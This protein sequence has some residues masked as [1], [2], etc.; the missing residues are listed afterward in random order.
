MHPFVLDLLERH[1]LPTTGLRSKSWNEFAQPGAPKMDF[2]ITVCDKARAEVC[3]VWPGQ[4]LSAH[5]GVED[6]IEATGDEQH[7]R[8]A[9]SDA[10]VLLSRRIAIFANLPLEKLGRLSLQGELDRIG[11]QT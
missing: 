1:H 4:P 5:W 8:R 3:P 11:K 7:R 10:L 6:P 2:V 9:F